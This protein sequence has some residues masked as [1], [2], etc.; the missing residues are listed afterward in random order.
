[1][2]GKRW[3]GEIE[4]KVGYFPKKVVTVEGE[5]DD[6]GN[7]TTIVEDS[8]NNS[9]RQLIINQVV[10]SEKDYLEEMKSINSVKRNENLSFY[11]SIT[12]YYISLFQ[13]SSTSSQIQRGFLEKSLLRSSRSFL[14]SLKSSRKWSQSS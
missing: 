6:G 8:T 1:M 12:S 2:R 4:G 3:K 11:F 14:I 13:K 5:E 10:E 7:A 9:K